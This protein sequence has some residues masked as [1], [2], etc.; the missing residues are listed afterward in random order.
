MSLLLHSQET[1]RLKFRALSLDDFDAWL[2][3]FESDEVA[4]FLEMDTKLTQ[5]ER[6]QKWFDKS[7]YR[8]KN[9]L[10][11]MNVLIDKETGRL[12][13]QCGLL[14]QT[15]EDEERLEIGYSIL[16]EF[17]GM[18]YATEAAT[19]C[20]EFAFENNLA[21]SLISQVHIDNKGSEKVARKNGMTAEKRVGDYTIFSIGRTE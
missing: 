6:C 10:G 15:V 21:K 3:L 20:K 4:I 11:G 19:K 1:T 8:E 7:F 12:V 9:N 16:P 13:G 5:R 17:W 2:P 18:G 14:V